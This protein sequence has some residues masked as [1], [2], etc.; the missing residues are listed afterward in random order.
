MLGFGVIERIV[1][2]NCLQLCYTN[3][4]GDLTSEDA[5]MTLL[6]VALSVRK[7]K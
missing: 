6:G 3:N 2:H 4:D 7:L 1:T 5:K